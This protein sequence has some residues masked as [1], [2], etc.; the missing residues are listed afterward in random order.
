MANVTPAASWTLPHP[1]YISPAGLIELHPTADGLWMWSASFSTGTTS[2]S[3]KVGEKWG[4]FA[5]SAEDALYY[6]VEELK[7]RLSG[8][9]R[10][11]DHMAWRILN[12]AEALKLEARDDP[13]SP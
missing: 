8:L 2:N 11:G 12:W 7:P 10:G 1:R 3:Y 6:A 5:L 4:H 13:A 9:G